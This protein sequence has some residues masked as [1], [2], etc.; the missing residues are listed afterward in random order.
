MYSSYEHNWADIRGAT[1]ILDNQLS[2]CSQQLRSI[3]SMQEK[4]Y[5]KVNQPVT[6]EQGA[7]LLVCTD[8]SVTLLYNPLTPN[9]QAEANLHLPF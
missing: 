2:T 8:P 1:E 4:S 3:S 5:L 9:Q 7:H 6:G